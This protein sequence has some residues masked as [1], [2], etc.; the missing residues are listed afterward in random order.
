MTYQD[1]IFDYRDIRGG[2]RTGDAVFFEG[3]GLLSRL[4]C[5]IAGGPSHV[6]LIERTDGRVTLIESTSQKVGKRWIIGVQRTYLSERLRNYRG[7]AWWVPL[8]E[9]YSRKILES[10]EDFYRL[11]ESLQGTR[12]D[13]WQVARKGWELLRLPRVFP[14]RESVKRLFCSELAAFVY[15]C[16]LI[17]PQR[18][19]VSKVTPRQLASFDLWL[20]AYQISG[21][22]HKALDVLNTKDMEE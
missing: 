7:Y 3:A 16:F 12:Y 5:L 9:R 20:S 1:H 10:K 8:H 11:A 19:N 2:V 14:L 15:K 22:N 18:V 13:F 17:L 4:I 21:P 6:A